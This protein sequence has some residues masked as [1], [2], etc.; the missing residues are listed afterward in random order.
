LIRGRVVGHESTLRSHR[1]RSTGFSSALGTESTTAQQG[2]VN[3]A[4]GDSAQP[5]NTRSDHANPE[6]TTP[7]EPGH[8]RP[9]GALS[10]KLCQTEI[11]AIGSGTGRVL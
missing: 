1:R 5:Q 10:A 3:P 2:P 7:R 8:R 11:P 6:V 9:P 4:S